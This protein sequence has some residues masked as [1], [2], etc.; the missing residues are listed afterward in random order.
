[1]LPHHVQRQALL[2]ILAVGG[3]VLLAQC[4]ASPAL[5]TEP[6][7]PILRVFLLAGQ[8]N[9]EGH[10][11]ADLD[12]AQ[13]YNGGRGNLTSL[14]ADPVAGARWRH[15]RETDGSWSARDD[16]FVSYR[17]EERQK[18][19]ALTLGYAV[20]DDSHHFGPELGIGHVLGERFAEPVLLIKT[21]WGGKSLAVDFRPPSAGGEIGPYYRQ[22]LDEFRAALA[23]MASAFPQLAGHEVRVEGVFWFQGWND[24]CD[25]AASAEYAS[26]LAHLIHDLR[27]ELGDPRLPFVAG[28]TGN[29]DNMILRAGQQA[30]CERAVG[31]N[32]R[33]V[34][35]AAFLRAPEDSP[36]PTHGH[37]WF[38]NAE[39]Y[40]LIGDAL[41]RAML[42][43]LDDR[44]Q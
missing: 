10:A 8:S 13:D 20:Y 41:S 12:D 6:A 31:G 3:A 22:M 27:V 43:L 34:P 29:M 9:M 19:G 30:G 4:A 35:T 5:P 40:L 36:N 15:L 17:T 33:F 26:N 44:R 23:S 14:L 37:H 21:A 11:V 28:E 16:V 32:S 24:G 42:E 1:M 18:S 7:A 38:G 2:T 25:D 39:S